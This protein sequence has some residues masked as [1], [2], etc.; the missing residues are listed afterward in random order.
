MTKVA[1]LTKNEVD[2]EFGVCP[3]MFNQSENFKVKNILIAF[4]VFSCFLIFFQLKISI[5]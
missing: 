1:L 5:L 3:S 4:V 2:L